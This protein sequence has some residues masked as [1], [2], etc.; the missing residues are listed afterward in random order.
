MPSTY[1]PNTLLG[2]KSAKAAQIAAYFAGHAGHAMDK[3]KL[4]KL[5]YLSERE[6]LKRHGAPMTYDE[7]FSFKDGPVCSSALNGINGKIDKPTWNAFIARGDDVNKISAKEKFS[8]DNFDELSD[9][10]IAVLEFIWAKFGHMSASQLR[11]F[12][13]KNCPE[14]TE[15]TEGRVPI[16]YKEVLEAVGRDDAEEASDSINSYRRV[17]A[18]LA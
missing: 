12:T 11:A 4:I 7:L 1:Q 13:H 15:V 17:Q 2:F 6:H 14:Y 18:L 9:A 8:R 3:M 10:D 16:A 5:I